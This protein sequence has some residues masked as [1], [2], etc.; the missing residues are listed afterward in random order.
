MPNQIVPFDSQ[1]ALPAYLTNTDPK[2]LAEVNKDVVRAAQFP[3]MSIKGKVFTLNKDGVRKILT[4]PGEEDEVAQSIGI[5]M[6]RS[7][8]NGKTWYGKGYVEGDTSPPDC[9]SNDAVAPHPQS[10][11]PQ[12]K[13]CQLCPR[14]AWKQMTGEDGQVRE[15][16]ECADVT[17]VAIAAP[18]KLEE[19]MLLRVPPKS[20]KYLR[21][22]VKI[23]DQRKIPYNAVVMKIN[24]DPAESSPVLKFK[25]IGILN[26]ADYAKVKEL[27]D[28]ELVRAIVGLDDSYIEPAAEPAPAVSAD[29]LD[30]AIAAR[31]ATQKAAAAPAPAPAPTQAAAPAPA[32]SKPRRAA[33]PAPKPVEQE[34][35]DAALGSSPAPAP[36]PVAAAPAAAADAGLGSMISDLD[37]LLGSSDD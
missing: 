21:E 34:E 27:Y 9:F 18:D 26:D 20:R 8:M 13:K 24:F 4:K 7:N 22:A 6:L 35:L 17:R 2:A 31:E 37:A 14:N 33:A 15:G 3:T 5:V 12:A 36:A 10:K 28:G 32:P 30:A 1:G 19:A 29:E 11:M 25:P 16:R 23:V